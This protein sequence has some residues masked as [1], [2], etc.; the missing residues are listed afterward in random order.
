MRRRQIIL[1][2]VRLL[3]GV[4]LVA[5]L[6]RQGTLDWRIIPR[7]GASLT[8]LSSAVA[9]LLLDL[10]VTSARL[11]VLLRATGFDLPVMTATRLT[12]IGTFFSLFLPGGG[13]GDVVRI[14]YAA[15]GTPG[16]R[17]EIT[18]MMVVDRAC[19]AYSMILLPVM[20]SPLMLPLLREFPIVQGLLMAGAALV[21]GIPIAMWAM[22]RWSGHIVKLFPRDGWATRQ[23]AKA[24]ATVQVLRRR[25]SVAVRALAISLLAQALSVAIVLLLAEALLP[26]GAKALMAL[27]IPLGYMANTIPIT[28]GG[29]G[30][31]EA[32]LDGLFA[33][34]GLGGGAEL[35]LAWRV[36]LLAPA[37]LGL[38]VYIRGR[39]RWVEPLEP[40]MAESAGV[41]EEPLP[42][43]AR[44]TPVPPSS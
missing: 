29:L 42:M 40:A 25:P 2:T 34:A 5:W 8:L 39:Q 18:T 41:P 7:L 6:V 23:L 20:L 14:Y 35:L 31:G 44:P 37:A 11:T 9:L 28:P 1:S 3:L 10:V 26:S 38:V 17:A 21:A 33:L 32:A 22:L 4:A 13:G 12:L 43:V 27:L 30:V 19:G 16:R 24:L 15:R 36:L